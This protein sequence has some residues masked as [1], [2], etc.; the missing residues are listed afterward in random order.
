MPKHGRSRIT[1]LLALVILII[2]C[3]R[4]S[5]Y[6]NASF[7]IEGAVIDESGISIQ[8]AE[9]F[10]YV[11]NDF[12]GNTNS[13][14]D[15]TFEFEAELGTIYTL[16]TIADKEET[17]GYDYIPSRS[18][19]SHGQSAN[20]ILRPGGSL[21]FNGDIQ[22]VDSENLPTSIMYAILEPATGETIKV[23]GFPL[24][25]GTYSY[26]LTEMMM[27]SDDTIVV[28]T[29]TP[30]QVQVNTS[31]LIENELETRSL[32]VSEFPG[33]ET[34]QGGEI[35]ID[36]RKYSLH[37]NIEVLEELI[38]TLEEA[39][40]DMGSVG[41]YLAV[42]QGMTES[43]ARFLAE[44][45]PLLLNGMYVESFD[46]L[47]LGYI[48]ASQSQLRLSLMVRDAALS[49]F[50]LIVFLTASSTIVAF[51]LANRIAMKILGSVFLAVCAL[52][53]LFLMFPGSTM[54]P[55]ESYIRVGLASI[56]IS[57]TLAVFAPRLMRAKESDGHVRVRNIMVP[58]FS[59][60]KRNIRRRKL[61]FV[62]TL[63][64]LTVLVMSFVSLTSFSNG[65]G[66]I[67]RKVS[68]Y[69]SPMDS[70]IIRSQGYTQTEP[71]SITVRE[72][73]SEW[74]DRQPESVVVSPKVE[75]IP[76]LMAPY[77]LGGTRI[78]GV[79]GIDPSQEKFIAPIEDALQEGTLPSTSG[80]VISEAIQ[81]ELDV[82]L[83]YTLYLN[84]QP[85][86]VEGVMDDVVIR[87][88]RE[89][90]GSSYL[91]SKLVN[92]D[93]FGEEPT[94]L[95]KIC[96][97]SEYVLV[98]YSTAL[99]L[100]L[101]GITRIATSVGPGYDA[102]AFAE[103]LALERGYLAWS[104]SPEGIHLATL[105]SFFEGKG[106]PLLVPWAIVVL[107]VVITMLNSMFERREE[108]NILS[109]V[110]LN[111]AQ[112]AAIFMSEAAIV[113]FT[114]GGLGYLAGLGVYKGLSFFG[115]ALEVRQKVSAFWSL[116]SIGIAMTAVLMGAYVALRSSIVIT[117]S[118]KRRWKI[119]KKDI[120]FFEPYE[121]RIP[122]RILQTA[123]SGYTDYVLQALRRL[124]THPTRS[125]SSIKIQDLDDGG[126]RIDFIY[127]SPG[128]TAENFYTKN[129]LFIE[130]GVEEDEMNVRLRC[131]SDQ[132]GAYIVGSL[133]RMI[134][135]RWST[136]RARAGG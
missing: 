11:G 78:F 83:G 109:S 51:I 80:I 24:I 45:A 28:P 54:V 129:T 102:K 53:I 100:V 110:G 33:L 6:S 136:A 14:L 112:I 71:I 52:I 85:L 21:V 87:G 117:P 10:V 38:E 89:I 113:G 36:I 116:A 94:I 64:S 32:I 46:A 134:S 65:Y 44:A 135:M 49:V 122:V 128:A 17:P 127:R 104:S 107:N 68:G 26:S 56:V 2:L 29:D 74:L 106:M 35:R 55:L 86:I 9:V 92:I 61:R 75:N 95:V 57:L 126:M 91:P 58:I 48:Q 81:S 63:I 130:K 40:R 66:L 82:D 84:D 8:G 59:I 47:K 16:Y 23:D 118:M 133:V 13:D 111:P 108:I 12:R 62:F 96:E 93:P 7:I 5:G 43:A 31:V 25:F 19:V 70:V 41:F 73:E 121:M 1:S 119:E 123:I 120:K 131:S 15:G 79:L 60:A 132:E 125:T 103:R 115:L 27:L 18:Q 4:F 90:D 97:P 76:T 77:S 22:Y 34:N 69:T 99:S 124:E 3:T 30:F 88:M 105:G 114:A 50:T 72:I 20:I 101:T 39:L 98:H 37:Q 67:V 42:E